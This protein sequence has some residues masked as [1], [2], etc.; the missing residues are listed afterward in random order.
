MK[1]LTACILAQSWPK[2]VVIVSINP[3][4]LVP[5]LNG[6]FSLNLLLSVF[7]LSHLWVPLNFSYLRWHFLDGSATLIE[8]LHSSVLGLGCCHSFTWS[9]S[10]LCSFWNSSPWCSSSWSLSCYFS[11]FLIVINYFTICRLFSILD[12]WGYFY[13]HNGRFFTFHF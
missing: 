10:S 3:F 5:N 7:I 6:L 12:A 1:F 4:C 8:S 11:T 13:S 2:Y 9:L